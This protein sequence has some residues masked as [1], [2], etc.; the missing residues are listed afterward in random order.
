M[1]MA[2]ELGWRSALSDGRSESRGGARSP[3]RERTTLLTDPNS[4][5][6]NVWDAKHSVSDR[7]PTAL[8]ASKLASWK[9]QVEDAIAGYNWPYAA[10]VQDAI[11]NGQVLDLS[12][13]TNL[14]RLRSG[15]PGSY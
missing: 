1:G 9:P 8:S 2:E 3:Q 5:T 6:I 4:D 15:A 7:F 10:A 11:D 14:R 13:P 12:F